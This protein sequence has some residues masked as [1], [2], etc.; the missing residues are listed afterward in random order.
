MGGGVVSAGCIG[1]TM[2]GLRVGTFFFFAFTL[3]FTVLLAFFFAP[4]LALRLT[5]KQ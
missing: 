3:R 5:G 4:F 2:I 1:S